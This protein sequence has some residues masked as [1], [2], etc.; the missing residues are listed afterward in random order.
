MPEKARYQLRRTLGGLRVKALLLGYYGAR[1]LGDDMMLYCLAR[2]LREQD[3][4]I[5]VVS[6]CPRD[7]EERFGVSAVQNTFIL[8]GWKD[9]RRR[10]VKQLITQMKGSDALIVGGGD[11]I[12]DDRGWVTFFYTVEKIILAL[13]LGKLVY[14]V[15]IGIGRCHHRYSRKILKATMPKCK[16]IIARDRGTYDYAKELGGTQV[17]WLPDIALLLPWYLGISH[18]H[19]WRRNVLRI[20]LRGNPNVAARYPFDDRA[21]A[22]LAVALDHWILREGIRVVFTPFQGWHEQDN[23]CHKRVFQSMVNRSQADIEEWNGQ[24]K[25]LVTNFSISRAVLAMRLHAGVISVATSTPCAMM[26]YDR[27]IREFADIAGISNLLEVEH[28]H[29]PDVTKEKIGELLHDVPAK[30]DFISQAMQW[31]Q[32]TLPI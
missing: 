31:R 24:L 9:A 11:L 4:D 10:S 17:L 2:W 3:V 19:G 7:T 14:L 27:K 32:I 18:S 25:D 28:L 20:C 21:A 6:E 26:P 29:D 16:C 8:L 1:N 13:I 12:R 5:T 22:H 15:N 23:D 30:A